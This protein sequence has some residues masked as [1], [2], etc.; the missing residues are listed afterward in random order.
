MDFLSK[1]TF[2]IFYIF[3]LVYLINVHNRHNIH[4]SISHKDTTHYNVTI[5]Q[6]LNSHVVLHTVSDIL[7][8]L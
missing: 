8:V 2:F 5:Q 4:K 1:K 6:K 7:E 3:S